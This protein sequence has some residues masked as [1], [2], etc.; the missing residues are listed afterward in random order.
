MVDIF[1]TLVASRILVPANELAIRDDWLKLSNQRKYIDDGKEPMPIYT[2]VRHEIPIKAVSDD[3]DQNA[4][5]KPRDKH[6]LHDL[7][8]TGEDNNIIS[9]N[10]EGEK[11][12]ALK[13]KAREESWFQWFEIT[14]YGPFL[15]VN[16]ISGITLAARKSRHGFL[17]MV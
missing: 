3:D 6:G 4:N 15:W 5:E 8:S 11:Q 16:L 7:G 2:A 1:G 14:P 17:H 9:G 13:Q 12:Q 10:L